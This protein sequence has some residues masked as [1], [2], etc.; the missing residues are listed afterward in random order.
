[1]RP[2]LGFTFLDSGLRR[3]DGLQGTGTTNSEQ[4]PYRGSINQDII[5][6]Y[7]VENTL[8]PQMEAMLCQ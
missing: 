7:R 3:N 2:V 1:M 6:P 8:L 5:L 4:L